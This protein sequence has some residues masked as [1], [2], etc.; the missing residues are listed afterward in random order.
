[1]RKVDRLEAK[2]PGDLKVYTKCLRA[3]EMVVDKCHGMVVDRDYK[4]Y[5]EKFK[6]SFLI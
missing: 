1:M 6:V 4:M 5:L 2:L 3:Y